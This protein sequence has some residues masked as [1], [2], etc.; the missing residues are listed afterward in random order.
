MVQIKGLGESDE[1][2]DDLSRWVSTSRQ[3]QKSKDDADKRAKLLEEMDAEF[4]VGNLIEQDTRDLKRDVYNKNHLKGL[5]VEHDTENFQEGKTIIL[6]LKDQ[7]VLNEDDDALINVNL[8]DDERYKKNV[9]NKKQNPQHYGYD[10]YADEIL[11]EFGQ[12]TSRPILKKYDDEIDADNRKKT[13]TIGENLDEE[14]E[15]KRKLLEVNK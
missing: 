2:V 12:P 14:K 6:T 4:G 13:F 7:D 8:I 1:E 11:D 15:K 10:V 9:E 3:K 5:R